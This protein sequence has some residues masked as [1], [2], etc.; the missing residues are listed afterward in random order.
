MNVALARIENAVPLVRDD[1]ALLEFLYIIT[2]RW[3]VGAKYLANTI[4]GGGNL[5]DNGD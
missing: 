1:F 5:L 3:K 4:A 2:V